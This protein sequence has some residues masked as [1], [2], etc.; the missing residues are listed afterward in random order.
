MTPA[1]PRVVVGLSGSSAP[2]LGR[3]LRV[4]LR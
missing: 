2:Q 4:R 3:A 1:A